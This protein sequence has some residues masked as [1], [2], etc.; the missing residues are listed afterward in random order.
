[1]RERS[2]AHCFGIQS[3][4][5]A[6]QALVCSTESNSMHAPSSQGLD[7]VAL[8]AGVGPPVVIETGQPLLRRG[9]C[10]WGRGRYLSA[11]DKVP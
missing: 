1:M 11:H 5:I 2:Q 7:G 3:S 10:V 6:R 9:A 4:G 8:G